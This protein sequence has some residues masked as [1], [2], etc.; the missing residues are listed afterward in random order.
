MGWVA[1]LGSSILLFF[2]VFG[3]SATVE[4]S[5]VQKQLRNRTALLI[6]LSMQFVLLP[7]CGFVVVK[8]FR[9]PSAVGITLLVVTSSPGGSYSNW[10]CSLFNAELALSVTMTALSTLLSTVMLPLNLMMYTKWAYSSDVVQQLNWGALFVSLLVVLGG[11]TCG[12]MGG[13]IAHTRQQSE[14]FHKRANFFGNLAG[15]ALITL[16]IAVSSSN[17]K[18]Q[19]WDQNAAFYIGCATPAVLGLVMAATL[20]TKGQLRKPERVAV[21]VESCYQNTGIAT[22]VALTM[23]A[24]DPNQL[25]TAIGVPLYYGLVVAVLLAIFCTVCW[26]AGWTKAP[27]NENVCKMLYNSYEV[28]ETT[29]ISEA[30]VS[31]EVVYGNDVVRDPNTNTTNNNNGRSGGLIF[32]QTDDGTYIVDETSL[33]K[34]RG[35]GKG[36]GRHPSSLSGGQQQQQRRSTT[37]SDEE[38]LECSELSVAP[39]DDD[40]HTTTSPRTSLDDD[41][42]ENDVGE[43]HDAEL[44]TAPPSN[45]IITLDATTESVDEVGRLGRTI[46]VLKAR[47]TGYRHPHIRT[48]PRNLDTDYLPPDDET[49]RQAAVHEENSGGG[50]ALDALPSH[51]PTSAAVVDSAPSSQA[52]PSAAAST[53]TTSRIRPKKNYQAVPLSLSPDKPPSSAALPSEEFSTIDLESSIPS[54]GKTL[55]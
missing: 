10:W 35:T 18:A 9:L 36:G 27:P 17:Q 1:E 16:S 41:E 50:D 48:M 25:A 5:Q 30:D 11:I 29:H 4:L 24:K 21:S 2:L 34:V 39:G 49:P 14:L 46:A 15:L 54:E 43:A 32:E 12:L 40:C 47:A 28:T 51:H 53:T 22:S 6:G 42:D 52:G 13:R 3:M 38:T 33:H 45:S 26:K 23:F 55:D 44:A 19:L 20:A 8:L 37:G 31:I 7:L